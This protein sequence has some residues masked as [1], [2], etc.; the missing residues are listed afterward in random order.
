[1][2]QSLNYYPKAGAA[3][4][5]LEA[6]GLAC[7][8]TVLITGFTTG[9]VEFTAESIRTEENISVS[10]AKS[11]EIIGLA[12]TEKVREGDK[13]FVMVKND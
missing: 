2:L 12:T 9:A 4:I 7:G 13:V 11:G 10:E 3:D 8:E 6:R 5:L 1:M